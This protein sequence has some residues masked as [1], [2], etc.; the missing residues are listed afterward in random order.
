MLMDG[1][2][3][4]PCSADQLE[5][6]RAFIESEK[7]WFHRF[8]FQG[9]LTTPGPDPSGIKLHHLC[10]PQSLAGRS[11]LDLGAY[12]GYF[13]YQAE[14]RGADRV[15]AV[16][17]YVWQLAGCSAFR[18]FKFIREMLRSKSEF[19]VAPAERSAEIL[20]EQFDVVLFLGVLYH[21]PKMIEYLENAA[22]LTKSVCVIETL[23]DRLDCDQAT[24]ALYDGSEINNDPTNS[25]APNLRAMEIILRRAGFQYVELRN[26]WHLNTLDWINGASQFGAVRSGRAVF[27]AYK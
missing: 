9:G 10:L 18:N 6:L 5:D 15:V 24:A 25:W 2:Y 21:D 7:D 27:H 16:D 22:A 3:P 19:V 4:L 8:E 13:T 26:I 1:S 12:E 23:L 20:Q 11:V 14:Q 17:Q